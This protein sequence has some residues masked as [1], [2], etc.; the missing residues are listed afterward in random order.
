MEY[1]SVKEAA[2]KWEMSERFVQQ[3]CVDGRIEGATKFG[4]SWMIPS[5]TPKLQD[6]R[7][8]G[9]KEV[10]KIRANTAE[11]YKHKHDIM[12]LMNALFPLGSC[13]EYIETIKDKDEKA[14]AQAEYYYY[15]GDTKKCATL[16]EKYIKSE[17]S[18][19]RTSALWLYA[20]ANIS[21]DNQSETKKALKLIKELYDTTDDTSPKTERALAVCL[22]NA[23]LTEMHLVKT[24]DMPQTQHYAY[25]LPLGLRYYICYSQAHYAYTHNLHGSA[26]GI[27]ETCL[28]LDDKRYPI[29]SIYLHLACS[30]CYIHMGY[31]DISA[32]HLREAVKYAKQDGFWQPFGELHKEL[33]GMIE[34]VMKKEDKENY[35]KII[36]LAKKYS[37][38]W[39]KLNK[40][41]NGIEL[42]DTLTP[43][44]YTIAMLKARDWSVKEIAAHLDISENAVYRTKNV[45]MTKTNISKKEDFKKAMLMK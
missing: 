35:R 2:L 16:A 26:V 17:I 27:A 44:E 1:M 4:K 18:E 45:I 41:I 32:H 8:R 43:T 10:E 29:V 14:I 34:F 25:L 9:I 7:K 20:F 31:R 5:D 28:G 3:C 33:G 12:P 42:Y 24:L 15:T 36:N 40:E 6:N 13:R 30:M 19:L 23:V 38:G 39:Q 11:T 22:Y 37:N 21:L